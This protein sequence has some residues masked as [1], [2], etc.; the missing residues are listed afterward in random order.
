MAILAA[1]FGLASL[2]QWRIRERSSSFRAETTSEASPKWADHAT[3]IRPISRSLDSNCNIDCLIEPL[4]PLH[5]INCEDRQLADRGTDKPFKA[6][7]SL[8]RER[9]GDDENAGCGQ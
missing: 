8:I 2:V 6:R 3:L 5:R 1:L 9:G 4:S 7:F